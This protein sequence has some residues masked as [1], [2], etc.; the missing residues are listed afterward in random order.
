MVFP[1]YDRRRV[2]LSCVDVRDGEIDGMAKLAG[3]IDRGYLE[4]PT[5][6]IRR[7][8]AIYSTI[9]R[10]VVFVTRRLRFRVLEEPGDRVQG[11]GYRVQ[12]TGHRTKDRALD[13]GHRALDTWHRV[14]GIGH[15]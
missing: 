2:H 8:V 10:E 11:T 1:Y 13:I 14:P 15:R 4:R 5:L 9:N 3:R 6:K 12:G 7:P